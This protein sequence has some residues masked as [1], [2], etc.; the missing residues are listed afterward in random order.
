MVVKRGS[1][2]LCHWGFEMGFLDVFYQEIDLT[3]I[4]LHKLKLSAGKFW[5]C[6][7]VPA[8]WKDVNRASWLPVGKIFVNFIFCLKGEKQIYANFPMASRTRR[9]KGRPSALAGCLHKAQPPLPIGVRAEKGS[10]GPGGLVFK[11]LHKSLLLVWF[12]TCFKIHY[13]LLLLLFSGNGEWF[14]FF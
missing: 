5:L 2:L 8:P 3:K 6:W 1:S 13:L 9:R 12:L 7:V 14:I 10:R 4:C 11:S